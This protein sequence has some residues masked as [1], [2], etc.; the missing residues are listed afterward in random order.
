[1]EMRF[2]APDAAS[3]TALAERLTIAF[4]TERISLRG[5]R[6]EVDI[7]IDREPDPGH[8]ARGGHGRAVVRPGSRRNRRAVARGALLQTR[9]VGSGRDVALIEQG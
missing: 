6:P 8:P 9:P 4:G 2:V 5:E 7:L 1:M 3:A